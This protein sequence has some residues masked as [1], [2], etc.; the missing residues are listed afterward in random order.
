[1]P[2]RS[3]AIIAAVSTIA[4]TQIASAADLPRKAPAYTPP[5][6]PPV[7]S[8]TGCYLGGQIGGG[9]GHKDFST[10]RLNFFTDHPGENF[11]DDISG[12]LAGGQVGCDWQFAPNWVIGIEGAAAWADI[13]GSTDVATHDATGTVEAK[14]DFLASVT[15][16]VGWTSDRWLL[17]GKGGVAWARDKYSFRGLTDVPGCMG[18]PPQ[19]IACAVEPNTPFDFN[20]SETRTGWT[21]GAGVEWAFLNNWSVK[22]EY[23]FYDFGNHQLNFADSTG[24]NDEVV[25]VNIDQRIQTIKL[26]VN[27]RFWGGQP[28]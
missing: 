2:R 20:A 24:N 14:T 12:V 6:P 13:K 19:I 28:Y 25:P 1:M 4:L 11:R 17:F 26:G 16:R 21:V 15:G 10:D 23:D 22:L 18:I 27:Y 9:W 5:P 7:F 3:L 8:W